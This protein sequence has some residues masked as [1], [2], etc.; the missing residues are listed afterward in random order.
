MSAEAMN[1]ASMAF[2]KV[3]IERALGAKFTY[4]PRYVPAAGKPLDT[5][6]H[7]NGASGKTV[8]SDD[9]PLRVEMP[10]DRTGSFEPL[11]IPKHERRF[12]GFDGKIVAMY[13]HGITVHEIQD[14][15]PISKVGKSSPS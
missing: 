7:L 9:S 8:M 4:H 15:W 12:T 10:R 13:A 3:L 5:K 14:F 1:A 11:L 2:K 6:K